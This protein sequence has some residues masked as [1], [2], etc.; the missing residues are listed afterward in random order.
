MSIDFTKVI[1]AEAK[2]A[3]AAAARAVEVKAECRARILAVAGEAAQT[4]I[5]QAGI[6]YAAARLDGATEVDARAA[7]GFLSGD[8][9]RVAE[10]KVWTSAMQAECRRAIAETSDPEWPVVPEGVAEFAARF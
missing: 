8:L 4:N 1:T 3:Q 7:V 2:A 5:A 9:M 10:W 6:I